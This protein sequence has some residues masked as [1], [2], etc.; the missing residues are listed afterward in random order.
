[1]KIVSRSER[2]VENTS[3]KKRVCMLSNEE[4][5]VYIPQL[6]SKHIH[7]SKRVC[8]SSPKKESNFYTA[9]IADKIDEKYPWRQAFVYAFRRMTILKTQNSTFCSSFLGL[10]MFFRYF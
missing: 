6:S 7:N 2:M 3:G 9:K 8:V 1:M 4:D 10:L 5:V